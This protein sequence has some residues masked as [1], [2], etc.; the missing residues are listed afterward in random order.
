M[1][2]REALIWGRDCLSN[3]STA[4]LDARLLLQYCLCQD[5][6]FVLAHPDH[7]LEPDLWSTYQALMG[8]RSH[9]EPVS[10][11]MGMKEFWGR[12]FRVSPDVLDPRPDSELLIEV[13]MTHFKETSQKAPLTIL[14]LGVG[15]GCL[16]LTLLCEFPNAVGVG[17]DISVDAL[18]IARQNA[19]SLGVEDRTRF[20]QS[21][22]F[23]NVTGQYD[24]LISN[25]PYIPTEEIPLLP[26]D[27][28][29]FDPKL[30]LD[31]GKLGLDFY[32]K[33]ACSYEIY[34]SSKGILV[35][36]VGQGQ[37]EAVRSFFKKMNHPSGN[38]KIYKDLN[39]IER[40]ILIRSE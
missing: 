26:R 30:A 3:S 6:P 19:H 18:A 35:L 12:P 14:E 22:L 24:C 38:V 23:E 29:E 9:G 15:S 8:R 34:L 25:P 28:R 33:I 4:A 7:L 39:G 27:V 5:A 13:T 36:E 21:D 31:G 10:K 2:I 11:I 17:V 40:C 37:A 1:T 16:L 32:Q 20:I